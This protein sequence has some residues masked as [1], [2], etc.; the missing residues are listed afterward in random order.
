M[1]IMLNIFDNCFFT[2]VI[3]KNDVEVRH[4]FINEN[5]AIM[6][7]YELHWLK[8]KVIRGKLMEGIYKIINFF[9]MCK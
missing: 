4:V 1:L 6:R 2:S 5:E 8:I 9:K 7:R 3:K